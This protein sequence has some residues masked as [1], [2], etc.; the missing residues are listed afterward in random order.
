[1]E[2]PEHFPKSLAVSM[3][4]EMLLF[5]IT[6]AVV[7]HYTC[8]AALAPGRCGSNPSLTLSPSFA[9][10]SGIELTTAPAYGSLRERL[11]KI[12]AGFVL[13]TIIIVGYVSQV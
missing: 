11:G 6:G 5:T 12:A 9:T 3:A 7:Y 8:V 4:A 2:H 1:M 13:P 10:R